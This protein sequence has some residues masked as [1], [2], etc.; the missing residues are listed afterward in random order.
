[1]LRCRAL[2]AG[3]YTRDV[4]AALC[5]SIYFTKLYVRYHAAAA[6]LA[7]ARAS[8][9]PSTEEECLFGHSSA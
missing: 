8:D 7:T 3:S 4:S 1:M 5:A 9:E 2:D 6:C